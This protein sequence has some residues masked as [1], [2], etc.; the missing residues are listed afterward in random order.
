METPVDPAL[1]QAALRLLG[2]SSVRASSQRLH[3]DVAG[4]HCG[5]GTRGDVTAR[6][7]WNRQ[8]QRSLAELA[9]CRD[10]AIPGADVGGQW[11]AKSQARR[12]VVVNHCYSERKSGRWRL[13][14]NIRRK[15]VGPREEVGSPSRRGVRR[16]WMIGRSGHPSRHVTAASRVQCGG[17]R[18][19][20]R[21]K[22][23]VSSILADVRFMFPPVGFAS[24]W[25][26]ASCQ[27]V[28]PTARFVP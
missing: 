4:P 28:S 23:V 20:Q 3:P 25:R 7:L 26:M 8:E 13:Q 21:L 14:R 12:G 24:V 27:V 9:C 22:M 5:T 10:N 2:A 19:R 16:N 15:A 17:S 18:G 6:P 11:D 1:Q